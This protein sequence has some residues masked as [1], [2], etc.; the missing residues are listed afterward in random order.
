MALTAGSVRDDLAAV[1]VAIVPTTIGE[2]DSRF[3]ALAFRDFAARDGEVT[4]AD[5]RA[6]VLRFQGGGVPLSPTGPIE[7]RVQR[8]IELRVIYWRGLEDDLD[9][10]DARIEQDAA[11]V[12]NAITTWNAGGGDPANLLNVTVEDDAPFFGDGFA[13]KTFSITIDLF[14]AA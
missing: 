2:L 13:A 4:T 5:D 9:A 10:L 11:D 12:E 6:F 14:R 8:A 3:H 1:L 7:K